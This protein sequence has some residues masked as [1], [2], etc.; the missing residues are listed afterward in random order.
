ML[1]SKGA[2]DLLTFKY[3]N[4]MCLPKLERMCND[5]EAKVTETTRLYLMTKEMLLASR[6]NI[7]KETLSNDRTA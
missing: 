4:S 1:V 7:G 5:V 2:V 6:G 3:N